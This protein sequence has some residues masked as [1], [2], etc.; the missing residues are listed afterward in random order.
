MKRSAGNRFEPELVFSQ[1]SRYNQNGLNGSYA[2]S[3]THILKCD[4]YVNL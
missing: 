1:N 4:S 2:I 3:E